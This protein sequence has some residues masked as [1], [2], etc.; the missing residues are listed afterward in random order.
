MMAQHEADVELKAISFYV[1]LQTAHFFRETLIKE[2][3][4][5]RECGI[6]FLANSGYNVDCE[7]RCVRGS[8]DM[9]KHQ[10]PA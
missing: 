9:P 4:Q 2:T 10:P 7:I 1:H 6:E 8:V 3:E 5:G